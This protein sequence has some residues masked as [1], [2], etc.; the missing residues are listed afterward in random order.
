MS[1]IGVACKLFDL[2]DTVEDGLLVPVSFLGMMLSAVAVICVFH[3][4]TVEAW[5]LVFWAAPYARR[6]LRHSF[7]SSIGPS[8][9]SS[10]G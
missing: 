8:T 9:R 1:S 10:I 6:H 5:V 4:G 7:S 2:K 3:V